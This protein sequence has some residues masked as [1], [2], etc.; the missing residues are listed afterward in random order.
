MTASLDGYGM[1]SLRAMKSDLQKEIRRLVAR[2]ASLER[3]GHPSLRSQGA[4]L[5][6]NRKF[7]EIVERALGAE[8]T[9]SGNA[10]SSTERGDSEPLSPTPGEGRG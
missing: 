5:D 2:Y 8:G 1:N 10:Q 3:Q 9:A 7:L 4:I 6:I